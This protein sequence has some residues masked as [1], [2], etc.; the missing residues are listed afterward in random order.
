MYFA[1]TCFTYTITIHF[2]EFDPYNVHTRGSPELVS[3]T[4][5]FMQS[6]VQSSQVFEKNYT[7]N[8]V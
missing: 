8:T 3:L 2:I 4:K 7:V 1:F 5:L 6:C